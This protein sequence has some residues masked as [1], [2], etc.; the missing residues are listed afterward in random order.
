M[1]ICNNNKNNKRKNNKIKKVNKQILKK[2]YQSCFIKIFFEDNST[3]QMQ[4]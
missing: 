2:T 1:N 4:K 3:N